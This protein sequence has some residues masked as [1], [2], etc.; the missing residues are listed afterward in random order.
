[1]PIRWV[2][3]VALF[4]AMSIIGACVDRLDFDVELK[5]NFPIVIDGYISDQ[6]GPYTVNVNYAFDIESKASQKTP[7]TVKGI[8]L[9]DNL[10]NAEQLREVSKGVYQT[11]PDGLRG[12]VG[13]VYKVSVELL[14]GEIYEST[15]D[16]LLAGGDIDSLY[17][18][19]ENEADLNGVQE[20]SYQFFINTRLTELTGIRYKWSMMATFQAE[21]RPDLEALSCYWVDDRCNFRPP[22]SGLRNIAYFPP[23]LV[24][25]SP[26]TCCTCW[27]K[28]F[29]ASP[30]L[31][32]DYYS[33]TGE[34]RGI[35]I[36]SVLVTPWTFMHKVKI[37]A[38][39]ASLS[40]NSFDFFEA[41]RNQKQAVNSLFQPVTGK[42]PTS[43]V[44]VNGATGEVQGLFYA[45]SLRT[46][47][48]TLLREDF[49]EF[50]KLPT[51]DVMASDRYKIGQVSCLT[52]FPNATNEKPAGWD[53]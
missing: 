4:L 40:K 35:K 16:T 19:Y 5:S 53:D 33:T 39:Q 38:Y 7:I 31:S 1:M 42:I 18:K 8:V 17:A 24:Q 6:P 2:N 20:D 46:K 14:S 47:Q 26:C 23:N 10:G 25:A 12:I 34:Y 44:Q 30:V 49:P 9:S 28:I 21:T 29:S 13:R 48:M 41:V 45:T 27:Y 22:C 43:F 36:G 15:P 51:L 50:D 37:V 32:D 11:R 3:S 52:M